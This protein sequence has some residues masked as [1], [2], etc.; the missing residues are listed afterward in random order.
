MKCGVPETYKSPRGDCLAVGR[1]FRIGGTAFRAGPLL[2][3]S[4]FTLI[5]ASSALGAGASVRSGSEA[6]HN[7]SASPST[8]G[9]HDPNQAAGA[10]GCG[11]M[12]GGCMGG[13]GESPAKTP[14]V[15]AETP[16]VVTTP[17]AGATETAGGSVSAAPAAVVASVPGAAAITVRPRTQSKTAAKKPVKRI[18]KRRVKKHH[19]KASHGSTEQSLARPLLPGKRAAFTG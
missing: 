19:S 7:G 13:G 11:D 8:N 17:T 3:G 14:T 10:N 15:V 1:S 6:A 9:R 4:L 12:C 18:V 5:F 2:L 16:A